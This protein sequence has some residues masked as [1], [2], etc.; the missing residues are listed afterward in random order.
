MVGYN[1]DYCGKVQTGT[2]AE[3]SM[4]S[5]HRGDENNSNKNVDVVGSANSRNVG[6][7]CSTGGRICPM[8]PDPRNL[9]IGHNQIWAKA[10]KVDSKFSMI[11]TT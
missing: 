4:H 3:G 6:G 9:G 1:G 7:V 2:S 5:D 10:G 11:R 8:K